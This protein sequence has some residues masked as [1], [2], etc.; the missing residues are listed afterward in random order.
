MFVY[1]HVEIVVTGIVG[2]QDELLGGVG[3]GVEE[4]VLMAKKG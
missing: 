3:P 2:V 1:V 4:D